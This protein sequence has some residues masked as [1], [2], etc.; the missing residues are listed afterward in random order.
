MPLNILRGIKPVVV[1]LVSLLFL[2]LYS[3]GDNDK[4]KISKPAGININDAYRLEINRVKLP[5]NNRGVI[6]NVSVDGTPEG[7]FFDGIGFLWSSGF[8][9]S[10]KNRDTIWSN[11]VASASRLEDYLPGEVGGTDDPRALLYVVNSGDEP[12][13]VSWQEWKDAVDLGAYF[14]DGDDNGIYNPI[15]KNGDGKWNPDEDMPDILGDETI[16]CV[17][18]DALPLEDRGFFNVSPMGIE[19]R[20]TVW[21]YADSNYLGN[22][23]FVRYSI[24]NAGTV[25]EV[26]DSVYFG[27]WADSDLGTYYDDLAGCDTTIDAGFIYNN[28][29]DG[30]YGV[31]PPSFI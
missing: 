7:G 28:G 8:M 24:N 18:N 21:A 30:D 9:L 2:A 23:I 20:Q 5:L 26:F 12:F 10:G 17:Y 1:I 25:A 29:P 19:I 14:Y 22:I 15:D 16:W 6:A 3:S 11:A 13:G 27:A 31:N 4:K